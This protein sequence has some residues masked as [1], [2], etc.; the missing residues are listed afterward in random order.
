MTLAP[1]QIA[2]NVSKIPPVCIVLLLSGRVA[3]RRFLMG[4]ST[5]RAMA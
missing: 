4:L 5:W 2:A 1:I 3:P